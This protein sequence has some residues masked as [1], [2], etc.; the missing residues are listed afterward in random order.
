MANKTRNW[1]D[2]ELIISSVSMALTLGFWGLFATKEPVGAS[3]VGQVDLTSA[4]GPVP[5]SATTGA[6]PTLLPGQT[7]FFG[8]ATAQPL[9]APTPLAAQP[10]PH[11]KGGGGGGGGSV[12]KTGSS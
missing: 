7:L 9:A 1:T 8:S 10:S 5:V 4:G 3:V 6:V 2:V 12:A 11:H